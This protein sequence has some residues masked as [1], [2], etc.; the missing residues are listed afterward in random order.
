MKVKKTAIILL[1][2]CFTAEYA[3]AAHKVAWLRSGSESG[4]WPVV[5]RFLRAAAH[6]LDIELEVI[7][8]DD[9]PILMV[10]LAEKTLSAKETRPDCILF[11]NHKKR[12]AK[13][14]ELAEKNNVYAFVFNAGFPEN[15][16]VGKPRE[17]Y[18]RWIGQMLPDDEYAGYILAK[19]LFEAAVRLET[20]NKKGPVHMVALE[21]N[22]TSEASNAR[23]RGLK[24][25]LKENK[26]LIN[27]QFFHSKWKENLAIEAYS[28]TVSRYPDVKLFW[29]ASDNMAIGITKAAEKNKLTAGIDYVTGGIDLLPEN[30]SYLKSGQTAVSVGGHYVEGVWALILIYDFLN[31]HD[32]KET[33]KTSFLTRMTAYTADGYSETGDLKKNLAVDRLKQID[34]KKFTR[35]HNPDLKQYEFNIDELI[36]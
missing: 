9:N 33:G 32:F 26:N 4:F 7:V 21:G 8:F 34:Y 13:I 36:K 5:E 28:A 6:D 15:S 12:G 30:Q 14:L 18:T 29:A 24:R 2:L 19:K 17:K 3:L 27:E 22:R 25:A 35:T 23:V 11:H 31:G 16:D 20:Y 1:F 10:Q